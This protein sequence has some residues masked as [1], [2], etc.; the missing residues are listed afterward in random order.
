MCS[1]DLAAFFLGGMIFLA[2]FVL[3]L[4]PIIEEV[5]FRGFMYSAI[6]KRTG[7][8]AAAFL[9]GAIFSLLHTNIV[10]FFP[11]MT[12][13]ILLAYLYETTGSLVASIAVHMVHN[14]IILTLVFFIKGLMS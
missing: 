1:S 12:L 7:I 14:S 9:S 13:G 5:F 3:L 10:G 8:M 2:I 4:G 6:R 11:I